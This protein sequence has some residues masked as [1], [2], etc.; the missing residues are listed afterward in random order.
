MK[1]VF[2]GGTIRSGKSTLSKRIYHE[3]NYSILELDTI[4]HSFTKVFPELGINE[5]DPKDIDKNFAPFAYEVLNCCDKDRKYSDIKVCINGFQLQPGTIAN[6]KKVDNM[7]VIYLGISDAT[8]HQ[9][10]NKIRETEVDGDWTKDKSDE[11]L[12]QIC[13]NII[14]TSKDIKNQCEIFGF[15]YFDTF[16]DRE[17]TFDNII[18][19]L[20]INN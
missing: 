1:N 5:K 17:G 2:I 7:I 20:R 13:T 4:V 19:Y 6:F 16:L 18:E 8:P 3:L 11:S 9:L 14:N 12:L 15:K 10:L